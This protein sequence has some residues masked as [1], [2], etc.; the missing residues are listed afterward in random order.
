MFTT[1]R[2]LTALL[3]A[4]TLS[5]AACKKSSTLGSA[6]NGQT[7]SPENL[8]EVKGVPADQIKA[9]IQKRLAGN[10]PAQVDA[11]K[12]GH[13]QRIYKLYD[14]AP[15][16]LTTDGLHRKRS[17]ALINA[18][19]NSENDALRID[20]FPIADLA[21]SV[22]GVNETAH[23]TADQLAE[24]DLLLTSTYASLAED[25]LTGQVDPRTMS[26]SW[27]IN[28]EDENVDSALVRGL[29]ID[30]LDKSIATMRPADSDYVGLQRAL[31]QYR[32]LTA[33]GGWPAI[34]PGKAVKAGKPDNPA[35]LAALR[36]RLAAE[37]IAVPADSSTARN[38]GTFDAGLASALATWQSRHG[39]HV[40]SVLDQPTMD[41]LNLPAAYRL[42]QI[43][44]NLERMRWLPR[45]LGARYVLVNV[46]EFHLEAHDSGKTVLEM[47]VIVGQEYQDKATPV[48]SDSMEYVVFRPYW[49]VTP[50]IA[51]K[52]VLPKGPEYLA[53]EN[54]ETYTDHGE[55]R[56]RQ[57]PGDKNA[58][59]LIKFM[60][61][62]DFNIYLHD[63]PQGE[64]FKQDIRAF[65]HGCI[66]L[67]KPAELA[68]FVLGWPL[69]KI[70]A[71]EHGQD[72]HTVNL[73]K[74]LPVYIVYF[75]T[76]M[77]SGQLMFGDDL[78]DRD[79]ALVKATWRAAAP[80]A[81]AVQAIEALKKIAA[82]S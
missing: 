67:E 75:T 53:R 56:V 68:Q 42:G 21:R 16:W 66:R 40:D 45:S 3:V 62:N 65:S 27:H 47:K 29:R 73:P 17:V 5:G 28:P 37:G 39:L 55:L 10:P 25:L 26:Q 79:D 69:D 54:M 72:D 76:Y 20:T 34:P 19:L 51:A 58:L 6:N 36:S 52:E 30:A 64:L 24:A 46:P 80:T 41:A 31:S 2:A 77:N 71:E 33:K 44:S 50:E 82:S 15:L 43:A 18:I 7:W 60:F 1:R 78:Y 74:K 4:A 13:V 11:H 38:P 22:S 32:T 35:R 59:G 70:Q 63:T 81:P 14:N 9:A 23:P 61:P 57:R 8:S 12:W 49:L 48:F